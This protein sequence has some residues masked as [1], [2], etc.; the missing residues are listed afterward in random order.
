MSGTSRDRIRS[1]SGGVVTLSHPILFS[2]GIA[3]ATALPSWVQAGRLAKFSKGSVTM[4]EVQSLVP[5]NTIT[6]RVSCRGSCMRPSHWSSG[7]F[8][9][10]GLGAGARSQPIA[11]SEPL[12]DG[13][14]KSPQRP[15]PTRSTRRRVPVARSK[16]SSVAPSSVVTATYR[17]TW[18]TTMYESPHSTSGAPPLRSRSGPR[19][20][21]RTSAISPKTASSLSSWRRV[22]RL[23]PR[24]PA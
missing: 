20:P 17:P 5:M 16:M 2:N 12:G 10:R 8:G 19:D 22:I 24:F 15:K 7:T 13:A 21:S 11:I 9:G 23:D 14:A 4:R 6:L 18:H 1:N 3:K